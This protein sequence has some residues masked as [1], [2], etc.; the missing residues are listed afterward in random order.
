MVNK[1]MHT[2]HVCAF[3]GAIFIHFV[4]FSCFLFIEHIV[5][6]TEHLSLRDRKLAVVGALKK[7]GLE[8]Q[9]KFV[10]RLHKNSG[11]PILEK[12]DYILIETN[13]TDAIRALKSASLDK[14][15]NISNI[16]AQRVFSPVLYQ[17]EKQSPE[18]KNGWKRQKMNPKKRLSPAYSLTAPNIWIDGIR[19]QRVKVAVFDTGISRSTLGH[20]NSLIDSFDWTDEEIN[21]DVVGHGTFVAGVIASNH[22]QCPGIAPDAELYSFRIFNKKRSNIIFHISYSYLL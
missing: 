4:L 8:G 2:T 22:E 19:G 3:I 18:K 17:G 21:N 5:T 15:S 6:F 7:Y 14:S 12:S 20:F 10:T 9:F 13:S 1:Y 11:I 16:I